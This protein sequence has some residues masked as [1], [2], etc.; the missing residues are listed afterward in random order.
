M[1][2]TTHL[3]LAAA[4]FCFAGCSESKKSTTPSNTQTNNQVTFPANTSA[5]PAGQAT[6]TNATA[7][8]NPAHGE[9]GHRCDIQV[10]APLNSAPAT[11]GTSAGAPPTLPPAPV[12]PSGPPVS[13]AAGLNPPHGQPG[14]DCSIAVGAPLK[15]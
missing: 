14:H 1:K 4:L 13:T 9:P 7:G 10:G 15:K 12:F 8:L 5:A 2:N 11:I 3:V 6:G